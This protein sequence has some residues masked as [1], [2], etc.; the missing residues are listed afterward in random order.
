[1]KD[2]LSNTYLQITLR[3]IVGGVFI[4]SS[5]NRNQELNTVVV[6]TKSTVS[7]AKG[8][9][10]KAIVTTNTRKSLM[11][12]NSVIKSATRSRTSPL[13]QAR[14]PFA[15]AEGKIITK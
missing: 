10:A 3:L 14:N 12:E 1:M 5:L 11:E 9:M 13:A 6:I 15:K 8:R 2:F 4:Y 7:L